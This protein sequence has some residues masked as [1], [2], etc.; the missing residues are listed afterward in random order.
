MAASA[1][2]GYLRAN[3]VCALWGAM[4]ESPNMVQLPVERL[5]PG[6]FVAALDRPWVETPF[7]FQGFR[8][9]EPSDV[10]ALQ[11]WCRYCYV[12][13][14]RSEASVLATALDGLASDAGAAP[15]A[16]GVRR[17]TEATLFAPVPHPDRDDFSA[18]VRAAARVRSEVRDAITDA[19]AQLEDGG[20]VDVDRA[21]T[22]V[23]AMVRSLRDDPSPLLWLTSLRGHE[24]YAVTHGINAAALALAFGAH[25]EMDDAALHALGLG[26]LLMDVGK[27]D[28]PQ[29]VLDNREPLSATERA[30]V[31]RHVRTGCERLERDGLDAAALEIVRLHHE[32]VDGSGY[33]AGL[34]GADIPRPALIAGIVDTYDAMMSWRPYRYAHRPELA[35]QT[36]LERAPRTFGRALV[37]EFIRC[38]G[39]FPAGSLVELDNGAIGIVVGSRPGAGL[40]PTVLMLRTPGGRPFEK[41]LLLNMQL[42][43]RAGDDMAARYIRRSLNESEADVDVAEVVAGEF[44]L[45][46]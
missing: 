11:G 34:S 19:L 21:R 4:V 27:V 44:G 43:D 9:A 38:V 26:T 12:D 3:R 29:A 15:R 16:A 1:P 42:A 14:E 36:M 31:K 37:E 2:I 20:A 28:I 7:P 35:L 6:L 22:S 23:G 40:W 30:F 39:T 25:L 10:E 13:R 8:V 18:Q 32:R 24:P 45:A 33:P 46:A 17:R 5:C 41:R